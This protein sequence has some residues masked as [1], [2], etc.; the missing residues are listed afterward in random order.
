M[1][2]EITYQYANFWEWDILHP[3]LY[4]GCS[5]LSMLGIQLNHVNKRG[6]EIL[7]C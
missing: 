4:N 7:L 1:W 3:T 2:D 5:Y 6:P